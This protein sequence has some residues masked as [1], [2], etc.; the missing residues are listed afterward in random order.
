M[1]LEKL[2]KGEKTWLTSHYDTI[3]LTCV[4]VKCCFQENDQPEPQG[5]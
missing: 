4:N 1:R 2:I 3:R 5:S